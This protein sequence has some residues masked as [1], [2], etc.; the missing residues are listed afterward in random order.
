M[1]P[2]CSGTAIHR[3]RSQAAGSGISKI[4]T[5][6]SG[7]KSDIGDTA[8]F[9]RESRRFR[10]SWLPRWADVVHQVGWTG[11]I[12]GVRALSRYV[13]VACGRF[14]GSILRTCAQ[15]RR[16]R[17]YISHLASATSS[18]G[19]SASTRPTKVRSSHRRRWLYVLTSGTGKRREILSVACAAGVAM[20]FGAPI[21][22]V[23]F[24]LEEVSYFPAKVMWRRYDHYVLCATG[25]SSED[26]CTVS[27]VPWSLL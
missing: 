21:G 10:E 3:T 7:M 2:T 27:S 14:A 22:G 19:S 4:K 25:S 24:S 16:D 26:P 6:L 20:A 15:A 13:H 8:V 1:T 9:T 18:A 17:L 5:I 11:T 23:L 12:C